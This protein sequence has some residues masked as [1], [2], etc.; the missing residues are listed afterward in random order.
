MN[1][2]AD[3]NYYYR[4][5]EAEVQ[6]R[7]IAPNVQGAKRVVVLTSSGDLSLPRT[8]AF[9]RKAMSGHVKA[10]KALLIHLLEM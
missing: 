7:R 1:A 4:S 3:S 10:L 8:R 6:A 2:D 5:V 9:A